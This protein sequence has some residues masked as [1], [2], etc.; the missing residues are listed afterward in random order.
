MFIGASAALK[1]S[2]LSQEKSNVRMTHSNVQFESKD[3]TALYWLFPIKEN[4]SSFVFA[5]FRRNLPV[6]LSATKKLPV[7]KQHRPKYDDAIKIE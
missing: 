1:N 4:H 7:N 2:M 3:N 6:R 5:R